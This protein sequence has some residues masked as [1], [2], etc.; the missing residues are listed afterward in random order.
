MKSIGNVGS[1][2]RVPSKYGIDGPSMADYMRSGHLDVAEIDQLHKQ[3][4]API[5]PKTFEQPV[6]QLPAPNA[7]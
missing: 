7:N 4:R 3:L 6:A 5:V 2:P 1:F